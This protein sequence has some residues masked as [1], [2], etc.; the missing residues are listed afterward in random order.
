MTKSIS[1]ISTE[2]SLRQLDYVDGSDYQ[3]S[4]NTKG[5]FHVTSNIQKPSLSTEVKSLNA[6]ILYL[7]V[8]DN[9]VLNDYNGKI[10]LLVQQ[11]YSGLGYL[12]VEVSRIQTDTPHSVRSQGTDVHAPGAIRNRNPSMRAARI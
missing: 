9:D 5:K 2:Y 8:Y 3:E 11:T 7:T 4:R 6:K 1:E 10:F 12:V